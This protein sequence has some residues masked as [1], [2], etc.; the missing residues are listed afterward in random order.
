MVVSVRVSSIGQIDLF[1]SYL[2]L[3]VVCAKNPLKKQVHKKYEYECT[4]AQFS[5]LKA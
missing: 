2:Y 1:K 4:M 5:K 3:I